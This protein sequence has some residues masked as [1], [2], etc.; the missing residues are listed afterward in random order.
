MKISTLA[1][2]AAIA[3]TASAPAFAA[4]TNVGTGAQSTGAAATEIGTKPA[5]AKHMK[6]GHKAAKHHKKAKKAAK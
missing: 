5:K 3:L 4:V 6:K 2:A 1:L